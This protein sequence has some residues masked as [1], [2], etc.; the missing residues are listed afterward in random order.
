MKKIISVLF[1][2][3]ALFI[4][5]SCTASTVAVVSEEAFDSEAFLSEIKPNIECLNE[6]VLELFGAD[7]DYNTEFF[8]A[9][10]DENAYQDGLG[11]VAI[12]Y[13]EGSETKVADYF[14]DPTFAAY[15]PVS[16]FKTNS[17][18]REYLRKYMSDEVMNQ[19]FHNDFLEYNGT[20]YLQRGARGYGAVTVDRNN[21]KY[22]EEKDGKQYVTADFLL[23]EEYDYTDLLEFT[24][25]D[26]GW[27]ITGQ[28]HKK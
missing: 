14:A 2:F 23:F 4:L 26:E 17:E 11:T 24:K 1:I 13:S 12:L 9:Y 21:I 5:P 6:C 16:N 25:T 22:V 15:Y 19:W 8:G 7:V 28:S 3:I 27:I 10:T 18:V 20:L